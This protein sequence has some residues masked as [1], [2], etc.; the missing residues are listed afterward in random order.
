MTY[1]LAP[2]LSH[3]WSVTATTRFVFFSGFLTEM[4]RGLCFAFAY[5][6]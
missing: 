6:A 3:V 5:L 1:F 2:S 4:I